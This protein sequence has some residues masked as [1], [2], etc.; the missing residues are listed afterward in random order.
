MKGGSNV[1]T[2]LLT[3][4]GLYEL[5]AYAWNYAQYKSATGGEGLLPF[6]GI[7]A[8]IGYPGISVSQVP[9]S[10]SYVGSAQAQ[11]GSAYSNVPDLTASGASSNPGEMELG[12]EDQDAGLD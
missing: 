10:S 4:A 11:G 7:G 12:Q 6:D 5:I 2:T 3:L 1:L 9:V 8:L